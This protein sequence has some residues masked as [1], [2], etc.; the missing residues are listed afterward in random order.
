MA[1]RLTPEELQR[2]RDG[3]PGMCGHELYTFDRLLD[4]IEAEREQHKEELY[5][6][7]SW[8]GALHSLKRWL[9]GQ[10]LG[11]TGPICDGYDRVIIEIQRRLDAW[12][13][14]ERSDTQAERIRELER[15]RSDLLQ[16]LAWAKER[17]RKLE[18]E[19]ER[20][21]R[22]SRLRPLEPTRPLA[23]TQREES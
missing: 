5:R 2:I 14:P 10:M 7:G 20:E 1:E 22:K 11:S 4:H 18:A 6:A 3:R 13:E 17:I 8:R 19:L 12:E 16:E 21:R 15:T 9:R 23:A